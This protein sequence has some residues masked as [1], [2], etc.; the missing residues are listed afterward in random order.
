[1]INPSGRSMPLGS[2]QLLNRID[3]QEYRQGLKADGAWGLI[4][5]SPSCADC[6]EILWPQPPVALRTGTG[7]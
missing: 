2:T 6:L 4:T 3:Y 5:L 1:M 7:L